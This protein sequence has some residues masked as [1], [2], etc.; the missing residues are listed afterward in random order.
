[1]NEIIDGIPQAGTAL[2]VKTQHATAISVQ[3]PRTLHN[4]LQSIKI[5][6]AISGERFYYGWSVK[7]KRTGRSS[8]IEGPSV[9]LALAACRCYTNC[10]VD[11]LPVQ[12]TADA[13]IFSA[14]FIDLESGFTL[15]RQFRQDKSSTVYGELGQ[16]RKDD[17]RFQIGQ[18]KAIRN[19]VVNA[20]PDC[21]IDEAMQAAKS[22]AMARLDKF[23]DEK[24]MVYAVD[25]ILKGLG[26]YAVTV[27]AVLLKLGIADLKAIDK[28]ELLALRCDLSALD[29]GQDY[30][31]NLFPSLA[32]ANKAKQPPK[33][34]NTDDASKTEKPPKTTRRKKETTPDPVTDA[35]T[36]T[37]DPGSGASAEWLKGWTDA[38][39]ACRTHDDL[40][41]LLMEYEADPKLSSDQMEMLACFISKQREHIDS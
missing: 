25:Q 5:E 33:K 9:K 32:E 16:A 20:V 2:Q 23:V 17:V 35:A 12:E 11:M 39:A 3:V 41:V 31:E 19:V 14:V 7:D 29:A 21:L 27:E 26:R 15:T 24:G 28:K 22:G 40:E 18:S 36:D 4:C 13:W 38:I 37:Q 10:A 8:M 6:A 30:A 1:M 34:P